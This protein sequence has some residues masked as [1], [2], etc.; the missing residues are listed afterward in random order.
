M[1]PVTGLR[2][3]GQLSNPH[4]NKNDKDKN[5]DALEM[6][7]P[8]LDTPQATRYNNTPVGRDREPANMS[9]WA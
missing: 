4:S 8:Q 9:T 7:L 3:P 6:L 5:I 1:A 2:A